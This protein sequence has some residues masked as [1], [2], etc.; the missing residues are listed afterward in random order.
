MIILIVFLTS[1]LLFIISIKLKSKGLGFISFILLLILC[2]CIFSFFED[3]I[4]DFIDN[5]SLP[6]FWGLSVLSIITCIF[7]TVLERDAVFG[8][9]LIPTLIKGSIL[10][11]I[12][13]VYIL[14]SIFSIDSVLLKVLSIFLIP[15]III[16]SA[17]VLFVIFGT[18]IGFP[19]AVNFISKNR[20]SHSFFTFSSSAVCS[21]LFIIAISHSGNFYLLADSLHVF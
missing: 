16:I 7:L 11:D 17:V 9:S 15:I 1:L 4:Y 20:K 8:I 12:T 5:C 18:A 6:L 19:F 14:N 13:I 2:A 10:S 3:E 21:L